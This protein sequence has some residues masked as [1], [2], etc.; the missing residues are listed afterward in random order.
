[1]SDEPAALSERLT[2]QLDF[3]RELDRLKRVERRTSLIDRSRLENSA[4]HSW[5]LTTMA[6]AL[7]EYAEAGTDLARVIE[8]LIV[9]DVVEIDAGDTFAFDAA[10]NASKADRE[11]AAAARL[12]GLLPDDAAARLRAAWEE[13]EANATPEA[14]FANALDRMQA[15]ILNDAA[16]DGGSWRKHGVSREAVLRRMDPIRTGAPGLWPVVL[17]AIDR[18]TRAGHIS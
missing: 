17:D 6:L 12:F 14:R 18:A 1:M 5:H 11:T 7:G 15:L 16:G 3:V 10:G 9:H 8:L 13:F 4:E 2:R